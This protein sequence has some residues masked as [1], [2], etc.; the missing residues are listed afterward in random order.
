MLIMESEIQGGTGNEE[1]Y[2]FKD[3][4]TYA[5]TEWLADNRKRYRQVFDEAEVAYI[6]AELSLV[7]KYFEVEDWDVTIE[8][9][10]FRTD[11]RS[12]ETCHLIL[13][14]KISATSPIAYIREGWGNKKV[15]AFWKQGAYLWE[16]WVDGKKVGTRYFYIQGTGLGQVNIPEDYL[17]LK[18]IK[19]YEA[20]IDDILEEERKYLSQFD[21]EETRYVYLDVTMSNQL[22]EVPWHLELITRFFNEGRELKGKVVK[23][24]KVN[25]ED[26]EI[27]LTIGWGTST[28]GSW[29]PGS[30]TAE[31]VFMDRRLASVYIPFGTSFE[32]GLPLVWLSG[33]EEAKVMGDRKPDAEGL[34]RVLEELDALI[35]LK[36]VKKGVREHASYMEFLRLRESR[37]FVER[38]KVQM[39]SVFKGNPGT[40]KTTVAGMMGAIYFQLGLLSKG[41]VHSVD[42]VDLVGNILVRQRLK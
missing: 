4:K 8:L 9:K 41:H 31:L 23:L 38:D 21:F 28:K 5:D 34:A 7:N 2:G 39:H 27:H 10:C 12:K 19:V 33:E 20:G 25:Q 36:Q 1:R 37:G 42:R 15:G 30:Y 14:R 35:G 24:V 11:K 13:K 26:E 16:A 18:S 32:P 29:R 3:L 17:S 22:P 40:G 6:Y